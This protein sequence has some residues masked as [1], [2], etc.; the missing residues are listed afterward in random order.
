MGD[1][2][3]TYS[4]MVLGTEWQVGFGANNRKW[5]IAPFVWYSGPVSSK[6]PPRNGLS[7]PR[8]GFFLAMTPPGKPP[9]SPAQIQCRGVDPLLEG[10]ASED[11]VAGIGIFRSSFAFLPRIHPLGISPVV[12]VDLFFKSRDTGSGFASG[13]LEVAR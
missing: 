12:C 13:Y 6:P 9:G 3:N 8:A 7:L 4:D 11:V 1:E 2:S 5:C 10:Q